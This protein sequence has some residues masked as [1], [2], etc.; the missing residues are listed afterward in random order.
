MAVPKPKGGIRPIAVGEVIRRLVGKCIMECCREDA[1]AQLWPAQAGVAVPGGADAVIHGARAWVRRNSD[2]GGK[3]LVKLDFTNAFKTFCM[4]DVLREATARFPAIARWVNWCY[5][6]ASRL[7]FGDS[8]LT[9]ASG[10]QQG[11][12]LGPLLFAT[13]LQPLAS[14]LR[15]RVGLDLAV[16]FLDDGVLAGDL[17]VVSQAVREVEERAASIG[18]RLN[19][20]KSEAVAVGRTRDHHMHGALPAPLVVDPATG[21]SRVHRNF[22]LLGAPIGD[23]RYC[24][25]QTADRGRQAGELLD[26]IAS[27]EDPQV[28][29][30]LLRSCAGYAR[31]THSMRCTPPDDHLEGMQS[32]DEGV[33]GCFSA[34]T[35]I[36]PDT[37]QWSQAGLGL[38]HGGLGLR[39]SAL[40]APAAYLASVG[41]S[42]AACAQLDANFAPP[43]VLGDPLVA[44]AL[45][46]LNRGLPAG[47]R[48]SVAAALSSR[49]RHL[50]QA[51]DE[52]VL[53][54]RTA[55][56]SLVD[57][58]TIASEAEPGARAFL[59]ATP[60][61]PMRMEPCVFIS[62]LRTR[63]CVP[64][65]HADV[66]CPFCD[67]V[68]D[69]F[70]HHAAMCAAGGERVLRHNAARNVVFRWAERA[71]LSP[72]LE[73]PGLL[74]PQRPGDSH[75]GRRRPADV[76]L[77]AL[78][79]VPAALDLA[80]TP[81]R[82]TDNLIALGTV[83]GGSAAAAYAATKAAHMGT[84]RECAAHG[85]RFVPLVAETTGAWDPAAVVVLKRIARAAAARE[86]GDVVALHAEFLQEL[87]V[88]IRS[89]RARAALRRRAEL[90]ARVSE[91]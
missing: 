26:A 38:K 61:G 31:V 85:I 22:E 23:G 91:E 34:F 41:A 20:A 45:Q 51:L 87:S 11:D 24:A 37:E 29:L 14:D 50:S 25:A 71:G 79:V 60:G 8:V 16:F 84:A 70:S 3:V 27:L 44:D 86:G 67:G 42:A 2:V 48:L 80:V 43:A 59:V 74:L 13:A 15:G 62:E 76:Y 30:R 63:L 28:A 55:R 90:S 88:T 18:L 52:A 82:R 19:L 32:F 54:R 35:G 69:R 53:A 65:S 12:P 33:R 56:A 46:S 7:R 72:E 49:Q 75:L 89:G 57:R 1:K 68:M 73:R 39:P 6:G 83:G 47:A 17:Q 81:P 21:V 5:G 58:A 66:W 40:H 78:A 77:P 64:D 4:E 36:H 10:V 9:S